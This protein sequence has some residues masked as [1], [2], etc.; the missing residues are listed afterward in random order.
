M[1]S[2]TKNHPWWQRSSE[3]LPLMKTVQDELY[4][5][6]T[7][8][9]VSN[10]DFSRKLKTKKFPYSCTD[11]Q[12]LL[13]YYTITE[14]NFKSGF[15]IATA[16]GYS[17]LYIGLGMKKTGGT[18]VT[19]DCYVEEFKESYLYDDTELVQTIS[20]IKNSVSKGIFPDGLA[21]AKSQ[22]KQLGL[23]N[24]TEFQIGLSPSDVPAII[25]NRKID[26]AFIDGGHFGEQP[27]KD[28]LAIAPY[29]SERC[30]VLFH[31]NNFNRYVFNAIQKAESILKSSA[32]RIPTRYNL[33]LVGR[34]LSPSFINLFKLSHIV[35][36]L[37]MKNI[38][39]QSG[40]LSKQLND[41]FLF[42]FYL[43]WS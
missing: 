9:Q 3:V 38:N 30:A 4:P 35:L 19:I 42:R 40:G 16:F 12:G 6:Y 31:D 27:T 36:F 21:F 32:I 33:T 39:T 23:E 22:S 13:L 25:G 2:N 29:L 20:D 5:I 41:C 26:F 24:I 10:F 14:N 1:Q 43:C 28:F 15:E 11:E 34:N 7:S 17:T 37:Y 8:D 18:C